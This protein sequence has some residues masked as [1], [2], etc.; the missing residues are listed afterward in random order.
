MSP[1]IRLCVAMLLAV[2]SV[3]PSC[4]SA[5]TS[6]A[7]VVF[8]QRNFAQIGLGIKLRINS[9]KPLAAHVLADIEKLRS[10][11]KKDDAV[12][13]RYATQAAKARRKFP[14]L[15]VRVERELRQAPEWVRNFILGQSDGLELLSGQQLRQYAELIQDPRTGDL[16]R[17]TFGRVS[18]VAQADLGAGNYMPPSW[19][20]FSDQIASRLSP[21]AYKKNGTIQIGLK[22]ADGNDL[23]DWIGTLAHEIAHRTD[24]QLLQTKF[25]ALKRQIKTLFEQRVKQEDFFYVDRDNTYRYFHREADD[26]GGHGRLRHS[27]FNPEE[28]W[29]Y[30][31][32]AYFSKPFSKQERVRYLQSQSVKG[33]HGLPL[34][35]RDYLVYASRDE[36]IAAVRQNIETAW[37]Q[38]KISP[39]RFVHEPMEPD[40]AVAA[41]LAEYDHVW[42]DRDVLR[43]RDPEMYSLVHA[44][45]S[46]GNR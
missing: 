40:E 4:A 38:Y 24:Y 32:G 7:F 22:D 17:S 37:R 31:V 25:P 33:M 11:M 34:R 2:V 26:F 35:F 46:A 23:Q 30:S 10:G 5:D 41:M 45:Y 9:D 16:V 36:A 21:K 18:F 28:Y 8:C 29:A 19:V 12:D 39:N 42:R 15:A 44:I 3:W 43:A 6:T 20:P 27:Y 13:G 14:E 1:S